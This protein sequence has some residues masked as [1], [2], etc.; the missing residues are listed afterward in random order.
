M[1]KL[2]NVEDKSL[3][4]VVHAM[5]IQQLLAFDIKPSIIADKNT[6]ASFM[7]TEEQRDYLFD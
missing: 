4:D 5:T 6:A 3:T 2:K 7:Q 1:S